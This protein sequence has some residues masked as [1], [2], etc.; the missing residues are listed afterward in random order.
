[1]VIRDETNSLG[2]AVHT[3][4]SPT[5]CEKLLDFGVL[6]TPTIPF[7]AIHEEFLRE[8]KIK[9]KQD[10]YVEPWGAWYE[11]RVSRLVDTYLITQLRKSE[12][13][14]GIQIDMEDPRII[15]SREEGFPIKKAYLSDSASFLEAQPL[16]AIAAKRSA[17]KLKLAVANLKGSKEEHLFVF[18]SP[19]FSHPCF[20][21]LS[22]YPKEKDLLNL[23]LYPLCPGP[24]RLLSL[25]TMEGA[26]PP[27]TKENQ[28][29][30]AEEVLCALSHLYQV[31]R[32]FL[33]DGLSFSQETPNQMEWVTEKKK[34]TLPL[35]PSLPLPLLEEALYRYAKED[36]YLLQPIIWGGS[37]V[38][39]QKLASLGLSSLLLLLLGE[40]EGALGFAHYNP[41]E[42]LCEKEKRLLQMIGRGLLCHGP[43]KDRHKDEPLGN[44]SLFLPENLPL[45]FLQ[46]RQEKTGELLLVYASANLLRLLGISLLDLP[47]NLDG[48]FEGDLR[49]LLGVRGEN[50]SSIDH[51]FWVHLETALCLHL[52]AKP[53]K[54][55][56]GSIFWEGT[57]YDTTAEKKAKDAVTEEKNRWQKTMSTLHLGTWEHDFQA[58]SILLSEGWSYL[59]GVSKEELGD[60]SFETWKEWMHPADRIPYEEALQKHLLDKEE[61]FEHPLRMRHAKGYY[62]ALRCRGKVTKKDKEGHPLTMLGVVLPEVEEAKNEAKSREQTPLI[63]SLFDTIPDSIFV[64]DSKGVYLWGNAPFLELLQRD[65]LRG[66]TDE[67]L[68]PEERAKA[69]LLADLAT[70]K[71]G[72][73]TPTQEWITYPNGTK[74]WV[75]TLR[76]PFPLVNGKEPGILGVSRELTELKEV[77]EALRYERDLFSE[78]PMFTILRGMGPDLPVLRVSRNVEKLLGYTPKEMTTPGFLFADLLHPDDKERLRAESLAFQSQGRSVYEQSYRLRTKQ[79]E[80]RWFSD[81]T[82]L[83]FDEQGTLLSIQGYVFDQNYQKTL[84]TTLEKERRR[85]EGIVSSMDA[86]TWE[87]NLE[88]K[89]HTINSRWAEMLGYTLEELMPFS[90]ATWEALTHSEDQIQAKLQM[91]QVLSGEKPLYEVWIRMRHKRGHWLWIHDRGKVVSW[92]KE[93]KPLLMSGTHSDVTD[94]REAELR[95]QQITE[96][97][98]DVVWTSNEALETDYVSPSVESVLRYTPK[99]YAK[100]SLE[101]RFP[102]ASLA[103]LSERIKPEH[104]IGEHREPIEV[105]HLRGD[106]TTIWM[107]I[108]ISLLLDSYQEVVGL[109]WVG[110]DI[111]ESQKAGE[112]L[113]LYAI[114][115]ERKN[116]E[117]RKLYDALE[118]EMQSA[119]LA[120]Q[121]LLQQSLPDVSLA[122]YQ[123][124]A[125]FIGGDLSHVVKQKDK[126]IVFQSDVT[127]HGLEGAMFSLFVKNTI[128]SFIE[129]VPETQLQP[130]KILEHLDERVRKGGYPSEYAVAIF[131]LVLDVVTKE[132]LYCAA[133]FQNPPLLIRKD[134]SLEFLESKGL[135]ITPDVPR[136]FLDFTTKKTTIKE[137]T[138]LLLSTDGLYEQLQ[139]DLRYE[140]RLLSQASSFR[141]LPAETIVDLIQNDFQSFLGEGP[142]SDDVTLMVLSTTEIIEYSMQSSFDSLDF[143]RDLLTAYYDTHKDLEGVI[144]AVHEM[145]ANAIEH[146]NRFDLHKSVRIGLSPKAI[147][148]EDE[149]CGF[150]WREKNKRLISLGTE[151]ERG[152]GLA[153]IRVLVGALVY[154]EKGN[155][156]SLLLF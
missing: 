64:K 80:Y 56:D 82:N 155:R 13:P 145:V 149:G 79:G 52:E 150:D 4:T 37:S 20:A 60:F 99:D 98:S 156:V 40:R 46:F 59:L 32:V 19:A 86:G 8:G 111:T 108:H 153:M 133:G 34:D 22:E 100:L 138:V 106:G 94:L 115:L 33:L 53:V 36:A 69:F 61:F 31:D 55:H 114:E 68:F 6:C 124:P 28:G 101:D 48:F 75:H 119:R 88:T 73:V 140:E 57:L 89:E 54:L 129:L 27:V 11:V 67:D 136:E 39:A 77:E 66:L 51:R 45:H 72:G 110:R 103:L 113:A 12:H 128:S 76:A 10:F 102:G 121:K 84:E 107:S 143:I 42:G 95:Y 74:R 92:S 44:P 112:E 29:S 104:L 139:G 85:L 49:E 7:T 105:E 154:N 126:L 123:S 117:V 5:E 58:Q 62:V 97:M 24:L 93:G 71:Q 63:P 135:P 146:G 132:A 35:L 91:D 9:T 122:S 3:I 50:R 65:S 15:F 81:R 43:K 116:K 17:E 1:M 14:P 30:V 26:I 120:H 144:M 47:W 147:V 127:G 41:L 148:V 38:L 90:F 131:V 96:N 70:Q 109:L 142:Q 23:Q 151:S 137:D 83:V 16:L 118:N 18:H 141:E 21:V 152:R 2:T 130:E 78:G 87:W 134:G 25:K 125:T